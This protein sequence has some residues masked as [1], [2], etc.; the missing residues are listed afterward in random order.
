MFVPIITS[1]IAGVLAVAVGAATN[2]YIQTRHHEAALR[3]KQQ[4]EQQA[5]EPIS[6]RIVL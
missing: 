1:V 5:R 4:Q 6:D 3:I 2:R